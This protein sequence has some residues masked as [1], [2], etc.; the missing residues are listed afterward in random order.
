ME[1]ILE[2]RL[3]NQEEI[4]NLDLKQFKHDTKLYS[5]IRNMKIKIKRQIKNPIT[6]KEGIDFCIC[7]VCNMKTTGALKSH[8]NTWHHI[9]D[10]NNF[11]EN[12]PD[13]PV[14]CETTKNKTITT[15]EKHWTKKPESKEILSNRIKGKNNPNHKSNTTK[16]KRLESSPK[17]IEF[18]KK[19]YPELTLNEQKQLLREQIEKTKSN[20]PKESRSQNKEYWIKKGFSEKDAIQKVKERQAVGSLENFIKRHGEKEGRKRWKERQQKWSKKIEQQYKNGDFSRVPNTISK[21]SKEFFLFLIEN[22]KLNTNDYLCGING[23]EYYRRFKDIE[24]TFAYDFIYK[25]NKKII[26]FNGDYWHMNPL[27][28]NKCDFNKNKQMYAQ[29]IW[30]YDNTKKSL[31]EK[32]GYDVLVIWES[33]YANDQDDVLKRCIEFIND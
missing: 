1:N 10:W 3:L 2:T 8:I 13:Y 9:F 30:E 25:P 15:G 28:Y 21:S 11:L 33:E 12:N 7:P 32:C 23:R 14:Y 5:K 16:Q 18:Y 17:S 26:E 19:Q 22:L 20:T 4:L 24:K 6:G 29:E 31:I 27:K